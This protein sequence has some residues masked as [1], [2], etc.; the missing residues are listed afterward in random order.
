M[1][2]GR[3]LGFPAH[4][5]IPAGTHAGTARVSD[6]RAPFR[7]VYRFNI[8]PCLIGLLPPQ[9]QRILAPQLRGGAIA[10]ANRR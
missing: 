5:H 6:D 10:L 9:P 3:D 8:G 4:L 1:P 2:A 7:A